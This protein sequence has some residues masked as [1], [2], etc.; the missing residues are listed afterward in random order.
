MF[1]PIIDGEPI[2]KNF[3]IKERIKTL[4]ATDTVIVAGDGKNDLSMLNPAS[5]S[6]DFS[7]KLLSIIVNKPDEKEP[8]LEELKENFENTDLRKI[9]TINEGDFADTLK[10]ALQNKLHV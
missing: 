6:D 9:I 1:T 10:Q 3:D 5:Y 4:D 8:E 7:G 2:S